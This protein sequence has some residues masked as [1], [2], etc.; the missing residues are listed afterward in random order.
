MEVHIYYCRYI[1]R[2]NY[3]VLSSPDELV[4]WFKET[5]NISEVK[6]PDPNDMGEYLDIVSGDGNNYSVI[7]I[8]DTIEKDSIDFLVTLSHECL[9][10]AVQQMYRKG[11]TIIHKQHSENLNYLHDEL[12]EEFL[13]KI[14]KSKAPEND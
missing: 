6:A 14:R 8:N 4:V 2:M 1:S 5:F 9:H 7:W 12:Y 11:M 3:L 13:K 10:A